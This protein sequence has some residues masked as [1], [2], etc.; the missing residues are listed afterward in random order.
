MEAINL[1]PKQ[2]QVLKVLL[3]GEAFNVK[4]LAIHAQ[5]SERSLKEMI[6]AIQQAGYHVKTYKEGKKV[7]YQLPEEDRDPALSLLRL[8]GKEQL[9]LALALQMAKPSLQNTPFSK[10]LQRLLQQVMKD[11]KSKEIEHPDAEWMGEVWH[12]PYGEFEQMEAALFETV[13]N[14]IRENKK[15][16]M[17]YRTAQRGG[18][19]SQRIVEPYCIDASTWSLIAWCEK[20]KDYTDFKLARMKAVKP[21][22]TFLPRDFDV[23]KH[24]AGRFKALGAKGTHQVRIRVEAA[25]AIYFETKHYHPTQ[26]CHL[27]ENGDLEVQFTLGNLDEMRSWCMSWGAGITVLSPPELI[28]KIKAHL[29]TLQV[30]YQLG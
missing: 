2:M 1:T 24:F 29:N 14:A 25:L 18:S 9:T 30:R 6:Q 12:F 11:L 26:Q 20:R 8:S 5:V 3:N 23:Q 10:T 16:Q 28:D 22:A 15:L 17:E 19:K 4:L 13:L 7:F 21:Q 27:L